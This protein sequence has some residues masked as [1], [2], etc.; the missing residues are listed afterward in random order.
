M[1][2]PAVI[3][4]KTVDLDAALSRQLLAEAVDLLHRVVLVVAI[5][6]SQVVPGVVMQE[7]AVRV[8]TFE[9]E[10][11]KKIAAQLSRMCGSE[12]RGIRDALTW[13]DGQ[14]AGEPAGGAIGA[15]AA[16]RQG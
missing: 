1:I 15:D 5:E 10:I 4:Q 9:F 2:I 3:E 13:L 14:L 8:G 7:C 12:D 16:I 6:K 11:G